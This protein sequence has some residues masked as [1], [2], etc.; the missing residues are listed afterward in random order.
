MHV[1][2]RRQSFSRARQRASA[3]D[4]RSS[5]WPSASADSDPWSAVQRP[6]RGGVLAR[7]PSRFDG[8][9]RGRSGRARAPFELASSASIF[10]RNERSLASHIQLSGDDGHDA[11]HHGRWPP[12]HVEHAN[13]I[14]VVEAQI[15]LPEGRDETVDRELMCVAVRRLARSEKV[16]EPV[17]EAPGFWRR[18]DRAQ[19]PMPRGRADAPPPS[20]S[21][22]SAEDR[23]TRRSAI[24]GA[25][26]TLGRAVANLCDVRGLAYHCASHSE[27]NQSVVPS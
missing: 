6:P 18:A 21:P 25:H 26:G 2:P 14:A 3:F 20:S 8:M 23:P 12:S 19:R 1:P 13:E 11:R 22:L 5:Y 7:R 27:L 16:D 15:H 10:A 17:L 9:E 4:A 24:V